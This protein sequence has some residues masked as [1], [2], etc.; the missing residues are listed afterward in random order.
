MAFSIGSSFG[1]TAS[2]I[3]L[4]SSHRS[5][6]SLKVS[7]RRSQWGGQEGDQAAAR[8]RDAGR[9]PKTGGNRGKKSKRKNR[10]K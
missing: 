2:R 3:R 9:P 4:G 8:D 5:G 6:S 7:H 10:G 1:R